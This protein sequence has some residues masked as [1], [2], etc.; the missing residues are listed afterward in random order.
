MTTAFAARASRQSLIL[1][2]I[3]GLH[4]GVLVLMAMGMKLPSLPVW[5]PTPIHV[6]PA[7]P[8]RKPVLRPELP[9]PVDFEPGTEPP[10]PLRIPEFPK[11]TAVPHAPAPP[12]AGEGPDFPVPVVQNPRLR[13]RDNRLAALVDACYPSASRRLGEEGRVVARVAIG[14]DGRAATSSVAQSSGFPRLDAAVD[15]VLRRLEFVPGRRDG[16]AVEAEVLLPIVFKL[17]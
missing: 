7:P 16:R 11:Q 10:P 9:G 5:V 13:T 3:V 12:H 6:P 8:P 17:N 15:C 1:A 14:A 4:V 2:A